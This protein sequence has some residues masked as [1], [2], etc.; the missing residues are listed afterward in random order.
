MYTKIYVSR[1]FWNLYNFGNVLQQH[2]QFDP[3]GILLFTMFH[4]DEDVKTIKN[5]IEPF[6]VSSLSEDGAIAIWAYGIS[7]QTAILSL[8]KRYHIKNENV[9][10]FGDAINDKSM[11]EIPNVYSVTYTHAKEYL[12]KIASKVIDKPK[13]DFIAQGI[14]C[15]VKHLT[16]EENN[17]E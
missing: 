6:H 9:C 15:F 13:S 7:K 5:F 8:L 11:F 17:H 4:A 3:N 16:K 10:V 2:L 14:D 12:Q 1:S